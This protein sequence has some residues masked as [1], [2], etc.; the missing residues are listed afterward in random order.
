MYPIRAAPTFHSH[1]SR[2]LHLEF[3]EGACTILAG[4]EPWHRGIASTGFFCPGTAPSL[5]MHYPPL[6]LLSLASTR[7]AFTGGV[8]ALCPSASTTSN[9]VICSAATGERLRKRD[10]VMNA[11]KGVVVRIRGNSKPPISDDVAVVSWFDQGGR[12]LP[13]TAAG[14]QWTLG[15]QRAKL[16]P[17]SKPPPQLAT[18]WFESPTYQ[19][20]R[21]SSFDPAEAAFAQAVASSAVA[22]MNA[23]EALLYL[24]S[25][26]T[27]TYLASAG[28]PPEVIEEAR[29]VVER[30]I[31]SEFAEKK[32]ASAVALMHPY[33][34]FLYLSGSAARS[35]LTAEGV[36]LDAINAAKR[37]VEQ[38]AKAHF[39]ASQAAVQIDEPLSPL[40]VAGFLSDPGTADPS[41]KDAS[42]DELV[43][44]LKAEGVS[45]SLISLALVNILPYMPGQEAPGVASTCRADERPRI[46]RPAPSDTPTESTP[47]NAQAQQLLRTFEEFDA[48]GS[49]YI[50]VSE[51]QVALTKAGKSVTEQECESI[52]RQ[53]DTNGDGQISFEEFSELF[54]RRT[55]VVPFNAAGFYSACQKVLTN[56]LS[57]TPFVAAPASQADAITAPASSALQAAFEEIDTDGSGYIDFD[58]LFSALTNVC[59]GK[60]CQ[61]VSRQEVEAIFKLVDTNQDGQISYNEFTYIFARV[62]LLP[63]SAFEISPVGFYDASQEIF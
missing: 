48:D 10:R 14:F 58:E 36:S 35:A 63:R 32:A 49:G 57:S 37:I 16:E 29:A 59:E 51:L 47:T 18:S 7:A 9:A 6:I 25:D 41:L 13:D 12:L 60:S 31:N 5:S 62:E 30:K 11:F 1:Q 24:T 2:Q 52:L 26:E 42:I 50:D 61:Y 20:A 4:S 43:A 46:S 23:D 28:N 19:G 45:D 3:S 38:A 54:K 55:N 33:E 44:A 17:P 53:V 39:L 34:A 27:A 8:V 22:Q 15:V 40:A 21:A 56:V